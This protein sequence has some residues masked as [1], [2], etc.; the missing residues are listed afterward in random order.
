M[1][2]WAISESEFDRLIG[3]VLFISFIK[4]LL[5]RIYYVKDVIFNYKI[6]KI[7]KCYFDIELN[8]TLVSYLLKFLFI[9]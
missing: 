3:I 6:T 8:I 1:N 5:I 4:I 2:Q 9:S 7:K